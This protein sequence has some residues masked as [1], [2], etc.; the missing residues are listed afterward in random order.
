MLY[1][2]EWEVLLAVGI[3]LSQ[4]LPVVHWNRLTV[5]FSIIPPTP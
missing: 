2:A 1:L 4:A 3:V 5:S